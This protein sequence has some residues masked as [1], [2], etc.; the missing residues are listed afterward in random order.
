[1]ADLDI[2]QGSGAGRLIVDVRSN[3]GGAI[4]A[5]ER[6]LI[7]DAGDAAGVFPFSQH[8]DDA[9]DRGLRQ[10]GAG[11]GRGPAEPEGMAALGGG[12]DRL[13]FQRWS[14]HGGTAALN[15]GL[16]A[17]SGQRYQGPVTLIIN[18]LS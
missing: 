9:A 15:P 5:A 2:L 3:P 16:V 4:D 8:A 7:A 17:D 1:M 12:F 18:A 6:A 11:G 10:E 14:D 13:G